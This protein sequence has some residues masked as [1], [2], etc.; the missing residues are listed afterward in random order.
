MGISLTFKLQ[1]EFQI[2]QSPF[3]NS[4]QE[5]ASEK[6]QDRN[7]SKKMPILQKQPFISGHRLN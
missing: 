1:H 7:S 2:K 6:G 5:N 3:R 4:V